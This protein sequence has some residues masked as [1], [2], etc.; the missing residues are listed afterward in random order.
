MR[1]LLRKVRDATELLD[2]T[3][4]ELGRSLLWAMRQRTGSPIDGLASRR[5]AHTEVFNAIAPTVNL[6]QVRFDLERAFRAAWAK[7][8][9][10]GLIEPAAGI[11][12]EN[13]FIVL[14]SEGESAADQTDFERIHVRSLLKPEML[15]QLLRK[16]PFE[17]FAG[18]HLGDAVFKAFK[19][20][21]IQ[22]RAACGL[23]DDDNIAGLE[24]VGRAFGNGGK[25][26]DKSWS[27]PRR[28]A[29][30]RL[31][32]GALGVFRNQGAHTDPSYEEI[33]EAIEEMM[34]ASR[35]LR[36]TD[37]HRSK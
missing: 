28:E 3:P 2:L 6:W 24:L 9:E 7:L 10:W 8:D 4:D 31:F 34:L 1:E 33:R 21:E 20:V 15:H 17:D 32:G 25:L 26:V 19:T 36:I 37:K 23:P 12:G 5:S 29:I 16:K 30:E 18:D 35:L 13:G 27:K 11:N 22:L 14:T